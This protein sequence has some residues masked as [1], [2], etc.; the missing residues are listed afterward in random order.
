MHEIDFLRI[1]QP[2]EVGSKS[3][4]AIAMHFR[5]AATDS[6]RVVVIDGGYSTT[7]QHLA[8]HITNYYSTSH[9]DLVISTHPDADHINGLVTILEQ[10][11]VGELLLHQPRLHSANVTDFSNI[12]VVDELIKLAKK[13][14]VTVTEPFTGLTRYNGQ[15][16]ILGPTES[17]YK[18]M[19]TQHLTEVKTGEAAARMGASGMRTGY[20]EK[21]AVLLDRALSVLPIETL[22]EDG[23]TGPRNNSSVIT[24]L[25][26]DD[27][28]MLFTGDAGIPALNAAWDEYEQR[29]GPYPDAPLNFF[30]APHH[31]SKRNLSPSLLDRMFGHPG[32]QVLAPT[33]VISSARNDPKHPS[34][35]VTNAVKRRK[36]DVYATESRTLCQR[37][38]DAPVRPHYGPVTAIGPLSED[39]D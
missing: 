39:D 14:G 24:L 27:E 23:D 10:L 28:R 19:I 38:N 8:D 18:D 36:F 22:G 37:S 2:G 25:T 32:T 1:E 35:K 21:A 9:I 6:E 12:E 34:P 5:E 11:S 30:Q 33:C 7:G 26:T 3:G 4:D 31:G 16:N 13:N 29:I 20:L 15:I 17:Y